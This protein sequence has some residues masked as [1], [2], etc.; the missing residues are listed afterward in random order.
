MDKE[1]IQYDK[2]RMS[3]EEF[4]LN[5]LLAMGFLFL[6]GMIFYD[7]WGIAA[8]LSL[9]GFAWIPGRKKELAKRRKELVK[10]QFKDA[11][12]F[13]SVSL[14]AGKSFETALLDAQQAMEKVY[15]DKNALI[16]KELEL[17]NARIMMNTPVEQAL[18]DFA[19]RVQI[20]EIRNF[21]DIFSISKR[22]G[23]NLVEVIKNTSGMIREKIEVKQEIENFI[24]EKKM[25]QK[26]L[27]VMPFV[28]IY[29][30]KATSSEFLD[31]L[32][33]TAAGRLIMT[34]ALLLVL[35]GHLI[36]KKIMDI[37]V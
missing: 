31:P 3:P 19:R 25:E 2:Y 15:P 33:N 23:A 32:Y 26:I 5:L 37:E 22:A 17:I 35:A 24:A 9:L 13:L 28:M 20:E 21:A 34:V 27:S 12:Y 30:I 29:V 6:V 36:A 14:S 11:L 7:H 10:L 4:I 8:I 1:V 18:E 16:I